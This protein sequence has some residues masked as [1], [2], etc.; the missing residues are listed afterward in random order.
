M[1]MT[2]RQ[3]IVFVC[4]VMLCVLFFSFYMQNKPTPTTWGI[5]GFSAFL[6]IVLIGVYFFVNFMIDVLSD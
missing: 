2:F 1:K 5:L 4:D 3:F 6:V